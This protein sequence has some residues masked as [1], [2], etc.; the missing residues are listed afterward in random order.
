MASDKAS[1]IDTKYISCILERRLGVILEIRD[2]DDIGEDKINS[3][4]SLFPDAN[5]EIYK[6]HGTSTGDLL[7]AP[8]MTMIQTQKIN[9]ANPNMPQSL[10]ILFADKLVALRMCFIEYVLKQGR[11]DEVLDQEIECLTNET[12]KYLS[13]LDLDFEAM[14]EYLNVLHENVLLFQ[15]RI[16][17]EYEKFSLL[18]EI[19]EENSSGILKEIAQEQEK[20]LSELSKELG[21]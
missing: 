13:T 20:A 4:V 7:T 14:T 5:L 6:I 9:E 8:V 1:N 2:N 19:K 18:R 10:A 21:S 11:D 17:E 12:L 3:Y 15:N 16:I